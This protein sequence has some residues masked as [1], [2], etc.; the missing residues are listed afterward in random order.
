[1]RKWHYAPVSLVAVKL[2]VSEISDET[3]RYQVI[4]EE[5]RESGRRALRWGLR[6]AV[7]PIKAKATGD[8]PKRGLR[9][10]WAKLFICL[11]NELYINIKRRVR[12]NKFGSTKMTGPL[13]S[14]QLERGGDW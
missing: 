2:A 12:S 5:S 11:W 14:L 9:I 13:A 7:S 8:I 6:T 1:L 4:V 10:G 3:E